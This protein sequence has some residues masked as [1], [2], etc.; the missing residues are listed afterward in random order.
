M[1]K[2]SNKATVLYSISHLESKRYVFQDQNKENNNVRR[3]VYEGKVGVN[4]KYIHN[5]LNVNA[6]LRCRTQQKGFNGN[7]AGYRSTM[8]FI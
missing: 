3:K 5:V 8:I 1:P 6:H 7:L 4:L 2:Y